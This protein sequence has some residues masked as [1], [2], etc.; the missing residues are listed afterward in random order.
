MGYIADVGIPIIRDNTTQALDIRNKVIEMLK[1]IGG[2]EL[3]SGCG[4]GFCDTQFKFTDQKE[5][6]I[7][8]ELRK[9]LTPFFIDL[10]END[11]SSEDKAYFEF[12][13]E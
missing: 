5:A 13:E 6:T 11:D 12:Y 4:H 1:D 3:G 9:L 8:G 10:G 2:E 7:K